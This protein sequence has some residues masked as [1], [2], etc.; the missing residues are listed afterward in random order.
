MPRNI[1]LIF[2]DKKT[3]V[4]SIDMVDKTQQLIHLDQIRARSTEN[5]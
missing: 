1:T 2:A 5:L 4:Y 3:A